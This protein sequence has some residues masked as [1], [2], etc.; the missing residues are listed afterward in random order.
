M[1]TTTSYTLSPVG[2]RTTLVLLLA[3]LAIWAFALWSFRSTLGSDVNP[4]TFRALPPEGLSISQIVPALLMLVLIIATPFLIWNLLEEWAARYTPTDEGL[5][6]ES[7]GISLVYPWDSM[8]DIRTRDADSD[9][10]FDEV[11]L[12]RSSADQIT[13]PLLRFLH[14]QAYGSKRLPIYS[15][16]AN[17]DELLAL[18]REQAGIAVEPAA[19]AAEAV[20][21]QAAHQDAQV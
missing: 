7:L 2:R 17:R 10:P 13:N 4:F 16:L 12:S 8:T 20:P 21:E 3:A 9:D 19:G 6:F 1:D 11:L 18:I 14:I 5:R 15:G